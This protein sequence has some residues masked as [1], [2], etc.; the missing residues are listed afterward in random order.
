MR[1]YLFI[2]VLLRLIP[3][4]PAQNNPDPRQEK[5][6]VIN[7]LLQELSLATKDPVRLRI[8]DSLCM[9][10]LYYSV[11]TDSS[12]YYSNESIKLALPL[13]DKKPLI[14]AYARRSNYFWQK[15]NMKS[16]LESTFEGIRLSQGLN[17]PDYLST[18]YNNII[19]I[20]G[21]Y[22]NKEEILLNTRYQLEFVPYHKDPFFDQELLSLINRG[23]AY[24]L[25]NDMDSA[26]DILSKARIAGLNSKDHNSKDLGF[27]IEGRMYYIMKK[28]N[29]ADSVFKAGSDECKKNFDTQILDAIYIEWAENYNQLGQV[30]KAIAMA[31]LGLTNARLIKDHFATLLCVSL[32][33]DY[34]EKLG[35]N[36]STLYYLKVAGEMNHSL[37]NATK[38]SGLNEVVFSE[39]IRQKEKQASDLLEREKRRSTMRLYGFITALLVFSLVGWMTWRNSKQKEKSFALLQ[40]QKAE[41][42]L[43]KLKVEHTLEELKATQAQLIQSEKMASLGDLTAGIAHEIQNPLNFVNNFSELNIELLDEFQGNRNKPAR[44][45]GEPGNSESGQLVQTGIESGESEILL[46]I[47]E[48]QKKILQHGKRADAIVKGMLQHSQ[49]GSGT[50]EPTNINAL[51]EEYLRLAYHGFRAREQNFMAELIIDLDPTLPLVPVIPQDMGRVILNLF[52]NAFWFSS[53][54]LAKEERTNLPGLSDNT[55][56]NLAGLIITHTPIITLTTKN[57]GNS[58]EIRIRDNGPGIPASIIG[59]IFQPFFTTKSTGQGTGLGLSLSYDI[60]KAHGG[61]IT[62]NN[63]NQPPGGAITVNSYNGPPGGS[64]N[65]ISNYYESGEIRVDTEAGKGLP[66][67]ASAKAGSEFIIQLPV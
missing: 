18:L 40:K 14:L 9:Y 13:L 15:T 20:Y 25:K 37:F 11:E 27:W 1:C 58:I 38:V 34:Y 35:I 2:F 4:L 47:M 50:K 29:E 36:D 39:Q 53:E 56:R 64:I 28:Y 61:T 57:L 46:T 30:R 16:A 67:E 51:A 52:N 59:K 45:E 12:L 48:N 54:A 3:G 7:H 23:N 42:D 22:G 32:L 24:I 26:T 55:E 10:Y 63:I 49:K 60:V 6:A 5:Q 17:I 44:K 43:Q 21:Q 66:A 31:Q 65:V 8:M 33:S 62:V 41:T 19:N